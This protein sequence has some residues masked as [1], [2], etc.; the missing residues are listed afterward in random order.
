MR[1]YL[2]GHRSKVSMRTMSTTCPGCNRAIKVEDIVV[3]SY[4]PVIDLQTCGM[5][6]IA[7]RGRVAAKRIQGGAGIICDGAMEGT[8]ETDGDV[9]LGPKASWKGKSLRSRSLS[10]AEGAKLMG[11]VT[12]SRRP[13]D[14]EPVPTPARK[15]PRAAKLL[16]A[17]KIKKADV[18]VELKPAAHKITARAV[19][20]KK[21]TARAKVTK[22]KKTA[23]KTTTKTSAKMTTKNKKT[24][25]KKT[26]RKK[27]R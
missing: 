8:I 21:T 15:T 27:K 26:S 18:T 20:T 14:E 3:K 22:K 7:K 2:C 11:V 6:R 24:T 19:A 23:K 25:K 4:I 10:V 12:I 9:R 13:A 1:C 17:L 5:I 16:A